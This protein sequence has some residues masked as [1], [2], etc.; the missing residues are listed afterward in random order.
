ATDTAPVYLVSAQRVAPLQ[1]PKR[2]G[3]SARCLRLA[4]RQFGR[5]LPGMRRS[6][7]VLFV[8]VSMSWSLG[9]SATAGSR[10]PKTHKPAARTTAKAKPR[11]RYT[12]PAS[13]DPALK[14]A[15][16]LWKHATGAATRSRAVARWYRAAEAFMRAARRHKLGNATRK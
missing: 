7:W 11:A 2:R 5:C 10:S 3:P 9:Q 1:S 6:L 4:T 14:R 13:T 16:A 15:E 8:G 12:R